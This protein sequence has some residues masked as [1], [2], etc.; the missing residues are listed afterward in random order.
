MDLNYGDYFQFVFALIFV[1]ALIGVMALVARRL[2]FGYRMPIRGKH[3]K[4][5]ALVEVLPLDAKRRLALVRRDSVE[6]LVLLGATNDVLIES[7][8]PTPDGA[9]FGA[10]LAEVSSAVE[11]REDI[12]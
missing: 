8:V 2:G 5:L 4:R 10:A 7:G 3:A 1:L 11:K 6:H 12:R 9:D